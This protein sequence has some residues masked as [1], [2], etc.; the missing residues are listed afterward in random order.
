MY[1]NHLVLTNDKTSEERGAHYQQTK[2]TMA[3]RRME[4]KEFVSTKMGNLPRALP[5]YSGRDNK[6]KMKH[7]YREYETRLGGALVK[8]VITDLGIEHTFQF[9]TL[10]E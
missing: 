2:A 6:F 4:S 10:E 8:H 1:V 9:D 3:N 5:V 7:G